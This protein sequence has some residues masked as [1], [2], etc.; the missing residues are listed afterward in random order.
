MGPGPVE[1]GCGPG[2]PRALLEKVAQPGDLGRLFVTDYDRRVAP[3]PD[4]FAPA[5][6]PPDLPGQVAVDE[7][8][9]VGELARVGGSQKQVAVVGEIGEVADLDAIAPSGAEEPRT[10]SL[11]SR[12]GRSRNRPCRVRQVTS[13]RLSGGT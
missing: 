11:R 3:A 1:G 6:Q 9:E 2:P 13:T 12:D 4:A 5:A 7:A 8:H 10:I